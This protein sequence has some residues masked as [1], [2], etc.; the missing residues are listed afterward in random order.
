M[1]TKHRIGKKMT[2]NFVDVLG[3]DISNIKTDYNFLN[4]EE[5]YNLL[6]FIEL[7]ESRYNGERLHF[8]VF[9]LLNENELDYAHQF[10]KKL[11][12]KIFNFVTKAY[13]TD[14]IKE[15]TSWGLNVH[16]VTSF[17]DP[18]VDIIERSPGPQKPGLTEPAYP[19]WKE[20]WDGYV[21]C[22][23][24]INDDYEGGEVFFPDRDYRFKPKAN[25]IVT[26]PGN[27][28]F[29]H[30]ITETKVTNRYVYGCFLKFADYDKYN[31]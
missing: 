16:K 15:K 28:N 22:N 5:M 17:T 10:V 27:K 3:T 1:K 23:I 9:E 4:E 20:S 8:R 14:F 30:G 12:D 18:H 24:Y 2:N 11:N 26:W 7:G 29:I 21:A 13:D 19:N 6:T 25:S 31:K